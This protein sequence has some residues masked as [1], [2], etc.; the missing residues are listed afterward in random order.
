MITFACLP[1]LPEAGTLTFGYCFLTLL[2]LSGSLGLE[3]GNELFQFFPSTFWTLC[4]FVIVFFHAEDSCKFL[5][6]FR[7]MIIVARH[8]IS[9]LSL[10]FRRPRPSKIFVP[11]N[12][13]KTSPHTTLP[14]KG[15]EGGEHNKEYKSLTGLCQVT[16][17]RALKNYYTLSHHLFFYPPDQPSQPITGPHSRFSFAPVSVFGGGEVQSPFVDQAMS[18]L[19]PYRHRRSL[20]QSL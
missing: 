6:A 1:C 14:F 9:L 15:S 10:S 13:Q 4:L 7:T 18:P 17:S 11:S 5:V 20:L 2:T 12:I 8:S 16:S 19:M 3:G